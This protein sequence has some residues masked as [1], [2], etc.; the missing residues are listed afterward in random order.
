[1]LSTIIGLASGA[2]GGNL[3]GS[4]LKNSSMGTLWNS[5]IGILGGDLG[6]Q[7]LGM[8]GMGG[9]GGEMDLM[10]IIGSVASG[11]AGGGVLLTIIGL[12]KKAM[13]K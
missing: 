13:G 9:G 2:L 4:L 8:L 3:A 10:G 12:V 6:S 11:G 5:V 7:I 1:M